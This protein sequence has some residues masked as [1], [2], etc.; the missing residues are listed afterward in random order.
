MRPKN[1]CCLKFNPKR[2]QNTKHIWKNKLFLR[3]RVMQ[4]LHIPL[5]MGTVVTNMFA[6]IEKAH[7]LPLKKDVLLLCHDLSPFRSEILIAVK[8]PIPGQELVSL[9]GEYISNAYD[10]SYNSIPKWIPDIE[11]L[12]R[13]KGKTMMTYYVHYAYCPKCSKKFGHNWIVLFAQIA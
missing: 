1:I 6:K 9:T 10:G 3:G 8:K 4:F 13:Q 5:N 12:C 2:Y 7:A 11:R